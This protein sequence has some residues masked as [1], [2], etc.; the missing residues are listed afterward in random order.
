MNV[1][2]NSGM[3]SEKHEIL[4][5]GADSG[6]AMGLGMLQA[7]S[8]SLMSALPGSVALEQTLSLSCAQL[9]LCQ[10]DTLSLS[11][12]VLA[13][14][15]WACPPSP[16]VWVLGYAMLGMPIKSLTVSVRLC[17]AGHIHGVPH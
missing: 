7:R 5:P 11:C 4:R 2:C 1:G 6:P 16:S 15:C 3:F 14:P 9:T 13:L 17:H 8:I 12:G 10:T